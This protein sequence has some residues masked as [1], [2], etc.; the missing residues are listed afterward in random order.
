MPVRTSVS[1]FM[2]ISTINSEALLICKRIHRYCASTRLFQYNSFRPFPF[3]S[4]SSAL[5]SCFRWRNQYASFCCLKLPAPRIHFD[6]LGGAVHICPAH[7]SCI[8]GRRRRFFHV[9]WCSIFYIAS[10]HVRSFNS[11]FCNNIEQCSLSFPSAARV[12]F[13]SWGVG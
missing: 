2:C 5:T 1:G 9:M 12:I 3:A 7:S 11:F 10:H 6:Y 4:S 8:L 13:D